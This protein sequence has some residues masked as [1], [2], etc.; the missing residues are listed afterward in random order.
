MV[1]PILLGFILAVVDIG[2]YVTDIQR[3]AAA[4]A[5]VADLASQTEE[6][7]NAP[8]PDEVESGR[9]TGVLNVAAREVAAPLDLFAQGAVIVT[10]VG[11]PS[12]RGPERVWSSRWGRADI[13]SKVGPTSTGGVTLGAGE[14]AVYAEVAYRFRPFILSGRLFGFEDAWEYRTMSVRRPRLA[15]P[16]LVAKR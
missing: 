1:T 9:E 13:V 12:G 7:E 3:V 4:A 8:N 10:L 14:A 11:N 5:A 2:R 16:K 6:F 15:G